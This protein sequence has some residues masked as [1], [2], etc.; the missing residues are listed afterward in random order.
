MRNIGSLNTE[1][2]FNFSGVRPKFKTPIHIV[3][4]METTYKHSRIVAYLFNKAI[5]LWDLS[6]I[7]PFME[8]R[9]TAVFTVLNYT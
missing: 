7:P 4:M 8:L 1:P 9:I 2:Q 3:S 6:H 5:K